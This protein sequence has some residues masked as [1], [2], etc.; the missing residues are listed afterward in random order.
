MK[1]AMKCEEVKPTPAFNLA[2]F[3]ASLKPGDIFYRRAGGTATL[4]VNGLMVFMRLK[5]EHEKYVNLLSNNVFNSL[6]IGEEY[7]L[8]PNATMVLNIEKK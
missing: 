7:F 1:V 3:E 8:A 5:Q 6:S 2:Q 4:Q